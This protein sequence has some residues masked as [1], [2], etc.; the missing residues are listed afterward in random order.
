[1]NQ[2][3]FSRL[4]LIDE[5]LIDKA[6]AAAEA[7]VGAAQLQELQPSDEPA[8]I[9]QARSPAFETEPAS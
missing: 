6:R 9:Y 1:M 5:A 3:P 2:D 7:A 4:R 8:H